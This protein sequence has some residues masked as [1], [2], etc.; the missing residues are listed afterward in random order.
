MATV[1][2]VLNSARYDLEDY[3]TGLIW[4][5]TELLEYLNRM[6]GVLNSELAAVD[7][8]LV[9]A[10]ETSIDT[11]ADSNEVDLSSMNSGL[12][13]SVRQVWIGSDLL[14]KLP[15]DRIRYKRMFR[16]ASAKPSYWCLYNRKILFECPADQAYTNLVVYY[17]KKIASLAVTDSM[18][19][20]D[21][22]NDLIREMLIMYAQARK[23]NTQA[24]VNAV[25][26]NLFKRKAMEETL[27]RGH[28]PKSYYIDF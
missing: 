12:W 3:Q 21:V 2:S 16:T 27:R 25:M 19:Y 23:D 22:F 13:D 7:S 10:E 11:V 1:Q 17:N 9:E 28:I 5:D 14:T 18:P 15:L 20:N 6:V 24:S 26:R 8:D 4:D